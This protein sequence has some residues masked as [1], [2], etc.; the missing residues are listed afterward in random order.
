M[1][2]R[3]Q[4]TLLE[5]FRALTPHSRVPS[6]EQQVR[7]IQLR[8]EGLNHVMAARAVK[9]T[10]TRLRML[11]QREGEFKNTLAALHLEIEGAEQDRIRHEYEERMYDREDPASARLLERRAMAI[12]P[13]FAVLRQ[14]QHQHSGG[15]DIRFIP[16]IDQEKLSSLS[17]EDFNTFM[18]ILDKIRSDKTPVEVEK[19]KPLKVIEGG[20]DV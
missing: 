8:L 18:A 19:P 20:K 3:A 14:R 11:A 4:E 10:G 16:W 17:D 9:S 7:Y 12:L 15:M 6:R 13:E 1:S 2:E 5:T